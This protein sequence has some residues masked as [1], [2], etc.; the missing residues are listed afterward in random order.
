VFDLDIGVTPRKLWPLWQL[1]HPLRMPR[2]FITPGLKP[3]ELWQIPHDCIVG[4]WLAGSVVPAA[5]LKV[6]VEVW[7]VSHGALVDIWFVGCDTGVT[8]LKL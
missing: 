6:A 3:A 5:D 8:P 2:W 7:H 1:V 4:K